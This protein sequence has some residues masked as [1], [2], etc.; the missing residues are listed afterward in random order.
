MDLN[1]T[2]FVLLGVLLSLYGVLDGFDLG[3]GVLSLFAR[4]K[5]ERDLCFAAVGPVW[6]GN[7]AWLLAAGN[8]L[9]GAFP[10]VFT[11]VLSGFYPAVVL[12]LFALVFRAVSIE[13]RLLQPSRRWVRFWD[14]G[15]GI[16]S[17]VPAVVFGAGAGNLLRGVPV[18]PHV[19]WRGSLAGLLNGQAL[20]CAACF[21]AFLVMHG[22]LYLRVKADGVEM[23]QR[24]RQAALAAYGAFLPLCA[25]AIALTSRS[26]PFL[27]RRVGSP[28]FW[29]LALPLVAALAAIPIATATSR[30]KAAFAASSCAVALAIFLAQLAM[31]PLLVPSSLDLA[32]SVTVYNGAS[33]RGTLLAM[34]AIAACSVPLV[35]GYTWVVYR[36]FRGPPRLPEE[37]A[38]EVPVAADEGSAAR[39]RSPRARPAL[40]SLVRAGRW[41]GGLG[42]RHRF[43]LVRTGPGIAFL[44]LGAL[45]LLPGFPA[46][47]QL[48][49]GAVAA[50]SSGL[51]P[52]SVSLRI[53]GMLECA[54][55]GA[56]VAGRFV[57]IAELLVVLHIAVSVLPL[58]LFPQ[59]A[60][61]RFPYAAS[62][63]GQFLIED[64][65][66]AG[67]GLV[68][69]AALRAS[70]LDVG[71]AGPAP[72]LSVVL[73]GDGEPAGR[74]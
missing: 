42:A 62:P 43:A 28:L 53:L 19:D 5:R 11:T 16:G 25:G 14:W 69:C 20:L 27:L 24:L 8:V 33:A 32:H 35:L 12:L 13:F 73:P 26:S 48:A 44:C 22:A 65:L 49:A 54:V 7:E 2:A 46:A 64:V 18:G 10:V 36:V 59:L 39:Y 15:F 37:P 38:A 23:A 31:Y 4:S 66:L 60:W 63:Q 41:M 55:G 57:R 6:D 61:A 72:Q 51:V 21:A 67:V 74:E 40:A 70:A 17:L 1:T 71:P 34:L 56:L 50:L 9:F 45:K 47:D 52:M 3:V 68:I 29:A 58:L 30:K